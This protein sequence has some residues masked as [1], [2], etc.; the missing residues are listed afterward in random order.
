MNMLVNEAPSATEIIK[1]LAKV[2]GVNGNKK[3]LLRFDEDKWSILQQSGNPHQLT[4]A[5]K[6]FEKH[7]K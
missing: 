4:V 3:T 5:L 2:I 6:I 7:L 1:E